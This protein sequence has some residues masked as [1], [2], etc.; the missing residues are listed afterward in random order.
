MRESKKEILIISTPKKKEM[1]RKLK[2]FYIKK[3]RDEKKTE[4]F[5]HQEK[6]IWKE[7]WNIST[8]R[9]EEGGCQAA[10]LSVMEDNNVL[11]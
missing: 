2:Y 5:L 9:K 6:K 4:I 1:K 8:T 11:T 10:R 3:T 7:N